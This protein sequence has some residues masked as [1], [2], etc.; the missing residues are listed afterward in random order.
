MTRLDGA[1][2]A[3]TVPNRSEDGRPDGGA[4]T[5]PADIVSNIPPPR[6]HRPASRLAANGRPASSAPP[7]APG[8]PPA[9]DK[10]RAIRH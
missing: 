10:L 5:G 2:S 9:V 6:R 7:V 3:P 8:S 4:P 1:R